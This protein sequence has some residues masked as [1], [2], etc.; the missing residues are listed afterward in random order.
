MSWLD[1]ALTTWSARRA[2]DKLDGFNGSSA[3]YDRL[4]ERAVNAAHTAK[5]FATPEGAEKLDTY[6]HRADRGTWSEIT[7]RQIN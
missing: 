6:A 7:G 4:R 3:E 5:A 1:R 2:L